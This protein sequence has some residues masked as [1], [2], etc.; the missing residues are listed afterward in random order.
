M[1]KA[2]GK[3]S[4]AHGKTAHP[5]PSA[6]GAA[7]RAV[8][9]KA[10]ATSEVVSALLRWYRAERRDLPWRRTADPYAI[11]VSEIMLQQ[12]RVETVIPYYGRFLEAFPSVTALAD[13]SES[14]V[15]ARW[16][17]LG[18]YR[19]ARMLH[20]GA[21]AV[22]AAGGVLPRTAEAL[23]SIPGIGR[24]TAGAI[25]SIAYAQA[26]PIVDGNVARVVARVCGLDVDVSAGAGRERV[27]AIASKWVG[28][29]EARRDPGSLNQAVM[30]LGALVCTPKEP[31]CD[32]CPLR[33]ACVARAEG[34]ENRLPV[35]KPKKAPSVWPRVAILAQRDGAWLLA[36]R[37]SKGGASGERTMGLMAGLWEPP[38]ADVDGTSSAALLEAAGALARVL[39][40][41]AASLELAPRVTHILTHRRML[42]TPA[43]AVLPPRF[44]PE[45][46]RR[47]L[48]SYDALSVTRHDD[49]A[50][51][52]MSALAK[53]LIAHG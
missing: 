41:R 20:A 46:S 12:T 42:V 22:V 38:M 21:K 44:L 15:L 29:S 6:Q 18:Y 11:W 36:R 48:P 14:D 8:G 7:R 4:V 26:A 16:S 1:E 9:T 40:L 25:A 31:R 28:E 3:R 34:R 35:L 10:A 51:L 52:P 5:G 47:A 19:R 23:E 2:R 17:G 24:Y 50:E 53:K 13:A 43:R 37:A 45:L 39:G 27:W 30:E 49:L 32:R 33:S